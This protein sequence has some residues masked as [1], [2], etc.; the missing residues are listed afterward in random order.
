MSCRFQFSG[1]RYTNCLEFYMSS[2]EIC[3]VKQIVQRGRLCYMVSET[4]LIG[5]IFTLVALS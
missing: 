3:E 5:N 2:L 1:A 4:A